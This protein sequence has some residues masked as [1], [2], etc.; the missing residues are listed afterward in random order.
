MTDLAT[1]PDADDAAADAA[2]TAIIADGSGTPP[3]VEWAPAQPKPKKRGRWLWI[4]V[5][6]GIAVVGL[7]ASSLI[8]IAPGTAVAGVPVGGLTAGAA[9]DAID[10]RL[11]ETTIVLTGEGGDVS[12]TGAELGASIDA[13]ALADSAFADHPMWN[14]GS[15]NADARPAA[16][17]LDTEQATEALRAAAPSLYTDPVD[18]AVEFDATTAAYSVTP[19]VEG[20]GIDVDAV[21]A[22]LQSAFLAGDT[23]V[24][25]DVVAAPV[26]ALVSTSAAE[27]AVTSLN[28]ILDTAGFYVGTE[29]TVPLDRGMVASWLTVAPDEDGV[30]A[31]EADPAAIQTSVDVLPSLVDRAPVNSVVVANKAGDILST[32][33]VGVT[34]RTLESTSGIA[35]SYADQLAEGQ[36]VFQLPVAE[37]PFTT[38]TVVRVAEVDLSEQRLYLKENDVVVDSWKI[39]SGMAGTPTFTGNYTIGW[40]SPSHT[41]NGWNRDAAGNKTTPYT[42]PDVKWSSYWGSSGQAFHAVTWHNSFGTRQSHGCVGMPMNRAEQIY[43]WAPK[44]TDVWIHD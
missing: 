44:G 11:A 3:T 6:A 37:V 34:G 2:D 40:K 17:A 9:A 22:A 15:W 27:A 43:A 31:I 21:Q 1:R 4:A 30:F 7:V 26:D 35:N 12:L 32:P 33:T 38:A 39:S 28:G 8:L 41:M 16:I 25:F 5:P 36:A 10:T 20:T 29:R 14:V 23:T 13:R 18:A 19:A 24:E 42:T